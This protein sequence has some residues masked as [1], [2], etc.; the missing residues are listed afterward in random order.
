MMALCVFHSQLRLSHTTE[1]V[2]HSGTP[3]NVLAEHLAK[4]GKFFL[5]CN[6]IVYWGDPRQFEAN[7][8]SCMGR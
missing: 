3:V 7:C 1:A 2:Y 8:E 6:K 4:F 5:S